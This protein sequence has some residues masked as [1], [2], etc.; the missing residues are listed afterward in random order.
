MMFDYQSARVRAETKLQIH[1]VVD[2]A[3]F[4]GFRIFTKDFYGLNFEGS[5]NL[6]SN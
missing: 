2:V 5:Y 4:I 1:N 6:T 3:R